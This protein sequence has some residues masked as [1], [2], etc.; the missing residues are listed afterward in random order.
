MIEHQ[1][2]LIASHMA[3]VRELQTNLESLDVRAERVGAKRLLELHEQFAQ[4]GAGLTL[5]YSELSGFAKQVE[6]MESMDRAD[7]TGSLFVVNRPLL[8]VH[9][10]SRANAALGIAISAVIGA[11]SCII[12]IVLWALMGAETKH[13]IA[14]VRQSA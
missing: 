2:G 10:S 14:L 4:I 8:D 13:I 12:V 7:P 5:S 6:V 11:L 1:E 9:R 3:R